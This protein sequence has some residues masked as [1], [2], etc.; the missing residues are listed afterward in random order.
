ANCFYRKEVLEAVGGFDERF[1]RPWREDS[2]LF[3]T[4]LEH[5]YNLVEVP[6]AVVIHPVFK[7]PWGISLNLQSKSLY[8]ALLYKKHPLLYWK[9]VQ[10]SPPWNYY[11]ILSLLVLSFVGWLGRLPGLAIIAL[12]LWFLL[13][14][15]FTVQRLRNT[16]KGISHILEMLATSMLIPPLAIYWRLAGAIRFKVVFL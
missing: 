8:N 3:F 12:F 2:D 9:Y 11:Q 13:T 7:A 10:P 1:S 16:D 5:N 4:L 14:L 15:R 6:Q